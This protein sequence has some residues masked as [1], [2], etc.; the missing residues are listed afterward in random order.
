MKSSIC[1]IPA[2]GGSKR[3]PRKNVREFRERPLISWSISAA[4]DSSLFEKIIVSTD[5]AEIA[6]IAEE[7]GASA[8]F[9]RPHDLSDDYTG[10][11]EVIG[12]AI[13]QLQLNDA[14]DMAVCCLYATAPF[15]TARSLRNG[16]SLWLKENGNH[17]VFTATSYSFP[18][19]RAFALDRDGKSQMIYPNMYGVRSQ[20]LPEAFHDAGQ[21]YWASVAQWLDNPR[22]GFGCIPLMLPRWSVQDIDTE[23]DWVQ[24][25]ILHQLMEVAS[26]K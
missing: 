21:F 25:E 20:D 4:V 10:T 7:H 22:F 19:Q 1:I 6:S 15:T 3:I 13:H 18:I 23:E 17:P 24:A 26:A 9:V 14:E 16:Y 11:S 2:R 8:P 12:H 5:D